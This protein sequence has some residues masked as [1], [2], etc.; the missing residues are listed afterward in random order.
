MKCVIIDDFIEP[1][2]LDKDI[3]MILNITITKYK[4]I[5]FK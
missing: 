5:C 3:E 4:G 1:I 2:I